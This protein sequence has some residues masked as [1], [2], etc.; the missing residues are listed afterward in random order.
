MTVISKILEISFEYNEVSPLLKPWVSMQTI[1]NSVIFL[2]FFIVY[3]IILRL[4]TTRLSK[5][6]P[7]FYQKERKNII[8]TNS[9][10]IAA[11]LIRI[12]MNALSSFDFF[13]DA[14]Q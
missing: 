11:I 10:I 4:L 1:G 3:I 9:I 14:L 13:L 8:A 2:V 7:K 6:Y 5:Q 12:T